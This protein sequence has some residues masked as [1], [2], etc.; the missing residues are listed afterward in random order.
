MQ[1]DLFEI[2]KVIL[3]VGIFFEQTTYTYY[4][5]FLLHDRYGRV[6]KN[7]FFPDFAFKFLVILSVRESNG[8]RSLSL[9]KFLIP[10]PQIA[11][12]VMQLFHINRM[13]QIMYNRILKL[14]YIL[15]IIIAPNV[16][17]KNTK[18]LF[19]QQQLHEHKSRK[20]TTYFLRYWGLK[21][22]YLNTIFC[23]LT[24]QQFS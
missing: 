4:P 13:C 18:I 7:K 10:L 2:K 1:Y 20:Y 24:K 14:K 5:T 11:E 12:T 23:I 19:G 16:L 17:L 8:R 3:L 22:F 9:M 15:N 6:R 21:I